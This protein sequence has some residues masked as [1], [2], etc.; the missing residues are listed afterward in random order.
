MRK[1][2]EHIIKYLICINKEERPITGIDIAGQFRPEETTREATFRNLNAAFLIS[3][4]GRFHPLYLEADHFIKTLKKKPDW[5]DA[6]E[7]FCKCRA[8][9]IEE[10]EKRYTEDSRFRK[11]LDRLYLWVKDPKNLN[12]RS[13][14][15]KKIWGIF[16]P[17]A[18][19]YWSGE[20][21]TL[22]RFGRKEPLELHN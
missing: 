16:S 3:L 18:F 9:I 1:K 7:F 12:N 10:I 20:K 19:L 5:K 11:N 21:I 14:T 2:F 6:I 17:K 8:L 13:E 22:M 15:V 4:C